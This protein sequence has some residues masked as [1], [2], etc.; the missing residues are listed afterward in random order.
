[1][2]ILFEKEAI[3]YLKLPSMP[4]KEFDGESSFDKGIAI[5]TLFDGREAYAIAK[6]DTNKD[7]K[8]RIVKVFSQEPFKGVKKIFVVPNYM[9]TKEDVKDMDLDDASKKKAEEILNEA[10]EVE[11]EG[12]DTMK[13]PE[14]EYFFEHIT[15][16]DEAKAFI[17]SYNER[18]KI[19]G[20]VPTSHEGIITRLAVIYAD[21]NKEE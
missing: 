16:D 21:T 15:N 14:N 3:K 17:K 1:M 12:T 6:F 4:K 11:N 20:R 13:E 18:N 19:R 9:T 10:E 8:P 7:V 2:E 5:I